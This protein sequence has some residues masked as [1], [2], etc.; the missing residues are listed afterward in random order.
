MKNDKEE[1]LQFECFLSEIS[2]K[3]IN[4]P[5]ASIEQAIKEDLGRL[6]EFL[7]ADRGVLHLTKGEEGRFDPVEL[8]A[9]AYPYWPDEPIRMQMEDLLKTNP[10]YSYHQYF[11]E[12]WSRGECVAFQSVDDL[13]E[14]AEPTKWFFRKFGLKSF[15]SV[16]LS[17]GGFVVGALGVATVLAS[18][19]WPEEL[20]PRLRL[21]AEVFGNA[22]LRKRSE[23]KLEHAYREIRVLKERI[24]GDYRY[25]RDEINLEHNFSEIVGQSHVMKEILRK[26][27][28]VAGTNAN[29]LLLG[30]T[31]TGKGVFARV[32]HNDGMR[33]ERPLVQVNCAALSP[34]LIESEFFGYEK[35]AFTGAHA[36]RLGRFETA[37]GSTLFLDE[38]G[39]IPIELQ[40]KLLR[41]LQDG[42]FERVGGTE[43]IKV[44]VRV[45]AATNRDLEREVEAGR[46]RID[47][48][49]R[50]S[51][52]PIFIPPLRERI[53]DIPL[54][55]RFF[56]NKYEQWS[57]KR[58]DDLPQETIRRLEHYEWPGNV[59]E[60]ENVI[61][62][63]VITSSGSKLVIDLPGLRRET[64]SG[65][66]SRTKTNEALHEIER[67]H[68]I[69]V[70]E[71]SSW[72]ISGHRGAAKRLAMNPNTLRG[73]MKK[74][75]IVRSVKSVTD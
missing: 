34:G 53:E 36:R 15:V 40:A 67:E 63:A 26:I 1:L 51:V 62:R 68:I 23:E 48:W 69:K 60:L 11:L 2:A 24:E 29:V 70:L 56:L 75:G 3:Y 10:D 59:R 72:R 25:L 52:F 28:Q 49:Y 12:R 64:H 16:P 31:G 45:V 35:G 55:V 37:N 32:L 20:I 38:I 21:F 74:L 27:K 33:K 30:E 71:A 19:V 43:T 44:D 42:E 46:F 8:P 5:A 47:L 65:A 13:P 50:L 7:G 18:R 22:L 57:G 6:V 4:L 17:V 39:E 14:E 66:E 58:F 41:V 9:L 73:R 61:E 54:F